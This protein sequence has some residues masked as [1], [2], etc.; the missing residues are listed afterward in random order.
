MKIPK[1]WGDERIDRKICTGSWIE[2]HVRVTWW[3]KDYPEVF[4]PD[5][6]AIGFRW[7]SGD[8]NNIREAR[9]N[10]ATN[11][12]QEKFGYDGNFLQFKPRRKTVKG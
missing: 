12:C 11:I 2:P 10:A 7:V 4:A 1:G 8:G 6:R 9:E 3:N 5:G